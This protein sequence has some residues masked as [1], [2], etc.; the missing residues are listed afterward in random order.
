MSIEDGPDAI[1]FSAVA[2]I[3]KWIKSGP[4]MMLTTHRRLVP[5]LRM[6]RSYTSLAPLWR[7]VYL[8]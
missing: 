4:G 3:P 5:T 7:S 2:A 8:L 6:S 1:I